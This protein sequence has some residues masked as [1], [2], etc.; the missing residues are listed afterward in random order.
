MRGEFAL[1]GPHLLDCTLRDGGYYNDWDFPI[2]LIDSYLRAMSQARVPVVELGFRFLEPS[3]Y[4]GP[5]AHTTDAFLD[6]LDIPSELILGVMVNAKD[7]VSSA[8]GPVG[9]IDRLFVP[10]EQCRVD[11]VRVATTWQELETLRPAVDH[12]IELGYIVGVNLM[13]VHARSRDELAEFGRWCTR[14]GVSVA[15]FADSFGGLS[16]S[17]I[18]PIVESIASTF[19][20][21]IG[22]HLHDNLSLAMANTLAAIDAGVMW[23]DST[24]RGM[25]RGPGNA[26]TEY[27]AIEL[28]RQGVLDLDVQP[29]IGLVTDDFARLHDRYEWGT[30]LFYVLSARHGV[31][32]TYVQNM[33]ADSRFDAVDIVAAIEQLGRSGGASFSMDRAT[34][35]S[36][37]AI[38]PSPGTWDATGWCEGRHVLILGPGDSRASRRR[39]IERYIERH[40]PLVVN[41]NLTPLIDPALVGAYVVCNP[42]RARLDQIHLHD[43]ATPIIAPGPVGSLIAQWQPDRP[44][45]DYGFDVTPAT[46][47]IGARECTVPHGLVAAYALAAVTRGT[48]RLVSIVGL[49]GF[50]PA[51]PRQ[52]EMVDVF[53]AF[54]THPDCPPL[55]SLTPTAYP[56]P[57]SSLWA[58][59]KP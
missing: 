54:T 30:N 24:I 26:R 8:L 32:P 9:A 15:Y 41:L 14:A 16:P 36:S 23:V 42:M 11:L 4:M 27:L 50:D 31:H 33:I 46:L 40:Q 53:E 1:D 20:G 13:Q 34:A 12:L 52:S 7:L 56:L 17:D 3:G 5:T 58:P 55:R 48:A 19:S 38:C 43:D 21:P 39:D 29:L 49:D 44:I 28:S 37:A 47:T 18:A 51:D 22:C 2:A 25:G 10:A 59:M 57:T 45:F 6:E 35:V